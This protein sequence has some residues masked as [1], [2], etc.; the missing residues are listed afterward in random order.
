M[1][2]PECLTSTRIAEKDIEAHRVVVCTYNSKT[3]TLPNGKNAGGILGVSIAGAKAGK[4]VTF[5]THGPAVVNNTGVVR[6]S[7]WAQ[8][9]DD[10][11]R[12]RGV[13]PSP[14]GRAECVGMFTGDCGVSAGEGGLAEILVNPQQRMP[15]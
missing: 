6:A 8:V 7:E 14:S 10:Q 15:A 2:A 3:C 12:A 1:S 9:A 13:A 4:K 5:V 11:G